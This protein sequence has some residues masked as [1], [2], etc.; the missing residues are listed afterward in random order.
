M[1]TEPSDDLSNQTTAEQR[2]DMMWPLALLNSGARFL[3]VG[4]HAMAVQVGLPPRRIAS[5]DIPVLS[6]E[7]LV[8]NNRATGR[9]KDV[10]DLA[11]LTGADE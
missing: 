9:P 4:A 7:D 3:V 10:A 11:V 2:L 8:R 1:G 5:R 6:R